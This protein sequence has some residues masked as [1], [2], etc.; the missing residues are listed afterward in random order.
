MPRLLV[1]AVLAMLINRP[2]TGLGSP[3]EVIELMGDKLDAWQAK[4]GEWTQVGSVE[5]D[6]KNP[7]KLVAK[8]GTGVW[9]NGPKGRTTNLYSKQKFADI[10]LHLEFNIPKGSNT[11]IKFH[12]HYEIQIYD[13]FGRK[14]VSGEDCGGI[15]SRAEIKNNKYTHLDKGI[16]P[17]VNACKAPG[18]WQTLDVVF[19]APRFD[20]DGNKTK[21][22]MIVKATLNGQVIHENQELKTPTGD[23]WQNKEMFEGPLMLQADHGPVAIRNLK[24]RVLK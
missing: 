15:Y 6:A 20:K 18:E 8:E 4:T 21:N 3:P 2:L 23:R 19:H 14:D 13:S 11:G 24:V 16:A 5:L 22:A 1:L 7:K 10:E 9:Y 12:G 17:K